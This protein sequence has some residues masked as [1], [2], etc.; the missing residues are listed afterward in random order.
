[1]ER[2]WVGSTNEC[3]ALHPW[4]LRLSGTLARMKNLALLAMLLLGC[5]KG[6]PDYKKQKPPDQE[7]PA[8]AETKPPPPPPKKALTPEE[9]GKCE[10]KATGAVKAEQTTPGGK[11]ATNVSYWLSADDQKNMMGVD[12]FAVT[13]AG[14]D[15]RFSM[16]PGGGK[17]DGMPFAP[18]KYDFK[19]GKGDASLLITFGPKTTLGD[20]SGSVNITAFDKKHIAGT[21]DLS[22]KLVPGGGTVKLTGQFDFACPGFSACEQ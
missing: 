12:G 6:E 21:I 8:I 14:S 5:S 1:M 20:P 16:V 3:T 18:K 10:L 19:A 17:K 11:A 13:C 9:M 4:S 7:G 22:G 15:I 2:A